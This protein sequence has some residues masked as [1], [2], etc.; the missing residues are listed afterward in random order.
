MP[1]LLFGLDLSVHRTN[2]LLLPAALLWVALRRPT[3]RHGM[4]DLA[5]ATAGFALGLAFHLLLIPLAA[6]RPAYMVEDTSTWAGLW[7]YVT[8]EQKGGGFL[9]GMVESLEISRDH[10]Q[11]ILSGNAC[12]LFGLQPPR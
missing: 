8:V 5:V 1:F 6:A 9:L 3:S 7:S 4:R 10:K 2:A 12:R 11:G